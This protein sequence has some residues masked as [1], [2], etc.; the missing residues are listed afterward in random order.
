MRN[1]YLWTE[2][3]ARVGETEPV[4]RLCVSAHRAIARCMGRDRVIIARYDPWNAAWTE[5]L[6]ALGEQME[7]GVFLV[8]ENRFLTLPKP[9]ALPLHALR[10]FNPDASTD[11]PTVEPVVRRVQGSEETG[12]DRLGEL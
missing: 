2:A 5:P 6:R 7:M 8:D 10:H 11:E 3:V 4:V 1:L 12:L 9:A